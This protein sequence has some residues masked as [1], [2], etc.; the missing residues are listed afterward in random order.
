M[1]ESGTVL[2]RRY[3]I[4]Q[5]LGP[6]YWLADKGGQPVDVRQWHPGDLGE[7][8]GAAFIEEAQALSELEDPG[9]PAL[10]DNVEHHGVHYF[11]MEHIG[12]QSL[13]ALMASRS[14]SVPPTQ[15]VRWVDQVLG[16]LEYLHSRTPPLTLADPSPFNLFFSDGRVRVGRLIFTNP[17]ATASGQGAAYL[18]PEQQGGMVTPN[19]HVYTAGALL[20]V[21]LT[22]QTPPPSLH[23][24]MH[25]APLEPPSSRNPQVSPALDAVIDI[26]MEPMA[27]RRYP[28]AA[29]A[30]QALKGAMQATPP[31]RRQLDLPDKPEKPKV[32]PMPTPEL[33]VRRPSSER[34]QPLL[35]LAEAPKP[36]QQKV[37]AKCGNPVQTGPMCADCVETS[38]A[39]VLQPR[40]PNLPEQA[41]MPESGRAPEP[42]SA[43]GATAKLPLLGRLRKDTTDI[44]SSKSVLMG[45]PILRR[46]GETMD[47]PMMVATWKPPE[48]EFNATAWFDLRKPLHLHLP[49]QKD[50]V[51]LGEAHVVVE[52]RILLATGRYWRY[53]VN[54]DEDA[55]KALLQYLKHF[56]RRSRERA[57]RKDVRLPCKF[58]ITSFDLPL[59]DAISADISPNGL[60]LLTHGPVDVHRMLVMKL[61]FDDYRFPPVTCRS[62]VRWCQYG[63]DDQFRIG[64]RLVEMSDQDLATLNSYIEIVH[65]QR[66]RWST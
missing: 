62:E 47:L 30:R 36:T 51:R 3:T 38:K 37:C 31:V 18:A 15:A 60:S 45:P 57:S 58:R 17:R 66:I 61:D 44:S 6:G 49:W 33:K 26:M 50:G 65:N 42:P 19:P 9:L 21:L 13:A 12:G 41:P 46:P 63:P 4:Q 22:A 43:G 59:F 24:L 20:Y 28:T 5:Q 40:P 29:E 52:P 8:A 2:Q 35:R 11:V 14:G 56:S 1:L 27:A 25:G 34:Q 10:L 54:I 48:L 55:P 16:V 32:I 53:T 23:R 39:P 7:N 64:T